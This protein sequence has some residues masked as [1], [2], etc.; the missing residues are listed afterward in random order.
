MYQSKKTL[1]IIT[2]R[3]GSKGV[4]RKNI[5]DLAGKPLIVYTIEAAKG[6]K[7]LTRCIVST[8]D[9]EIAAVA[10]QSGGDIPFMR[11]AELAQDD[12]TS[13]AVAQHTIT[14]LKDNQGE[15]YDYIMILQP[16][17]PLRTAADIDACIQKIVDTGADSVISVKELVDFSLKKFKKIVDDQILPYVEDEG[18]TPLPRHKLEKIYKRNASIFLTK[19]ELVMRGD[20]FGQVS[21]PYLMP[22]ERSVDIN[23]LVDFDLAEFFMSKIK[24]A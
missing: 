11:L 16:T 4:P 18:I 6:S 24:N 20:L 9:E 21:R 14:W 10:K 1:G 3:G 17:S 23:S 19:T 13:I 2:A 22:E 12:S 5:K 15:N 8:D 7:H